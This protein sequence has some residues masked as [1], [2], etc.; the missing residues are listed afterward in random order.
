M[1]GVEWRQIER[2][3]LFFGV[4]GAF[5]ASS[6]GEAAE[7]LVRPDHALVEMHS[8]FASV[9]TFIYGALLAGEFLAIINPMAFMS[10][11]FFA[12]L[13][14]LAVFLEKILTNK[15]LSVILAVLGLI[16][17]SVTGMLGGAMVYGSSADPILPFVLKLL[18]LGSPV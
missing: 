14:P 16:A 2:A 1:P 9:S 10:R 6:S 3:L 4:L 8:A 5:A 11:S 17:I 13:K 7:H 18:G 12:V 15:V